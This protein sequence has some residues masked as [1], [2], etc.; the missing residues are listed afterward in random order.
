MLGLTMVESNAYYLLPQPG[1]P[2]FTSE[3]PPP[4]H[5]KAP[6]FT[7]NP[8]AKGRL[9]VFHDSFAMN[10]IEL[11]AYHFQQ[12]HYLWQYELNPAAIEK[13][14]PDIVVSEMNECYFNIE[15]PKELMTQDALN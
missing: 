6:K 1:L 15:S 2:A 14:K 5:P 7:R 12:V 3:L 11:L 4:E 10:W 8:T 9:L 13:E